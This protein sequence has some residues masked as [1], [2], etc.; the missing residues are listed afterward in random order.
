MP[1][2][3]ENLL[4]K[5]QWSDFARRRMPAP[6]PGQ[7][8]VAARTD[9][10][11]RPFAWSL[12]PVPGSKPTI[13]RLSDNI[14][15]TIDLNRSSSWVAEWVF[16]QPQQ[17][18]D[19]LLVHEQGHYNV[20]ALMARDLFIDL[21][22]LKQNDYTNQNTAV[23]EI[24]AVLGRY[25]TPVIQAV[26]KKY[27]SDPETKHGANTPAQQRWNGY[28]TSA[29]TQPRTPATAAPDGTPHRM[30]LLQVLKNAG[31]YP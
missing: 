11:Y 2:K 26:N 24:N 1:S 31:V 27:D 19:D 14:T 22:L 16:Q 21:M 15:I 29:F 28:F 18:Q 6:A 25:G 10:A 17:F 23:S 9:V 4:R 3:L 5:V 13:V 7:T 20:T 30:P 12:A 8:M